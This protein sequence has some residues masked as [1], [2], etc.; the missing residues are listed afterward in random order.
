MSASVEYRVIWQR[1]GGTRPKVRRYVRRVKA[2]AMLAFLTGDPHARCEGHV[3]FCVWDRWAHT[4]K[5]SE[6]PPWRI[7]P[8]MEAREVG[9]WRCGA[10]GEDHSNGCPASATYP[11]ESQP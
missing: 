7:E 9:P 5:P 10:F 3:E 1:E 2:E 8:R 6:P 4:N 11:L